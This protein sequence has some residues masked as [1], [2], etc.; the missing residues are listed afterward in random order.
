MS[1]GFD[2]KTIRPPAPKPV[3]V[4]DIGTTSIRMAVAEI[5]DGGNVRPLE[6]LSLAVSLGK[7]TF[8]KGRITK[9][10]IEECVNVLKSYRQVLTEYQINSPDQIR[11][12]ATSA[13]REAS[14]RLAFLDRI[15][16][17]TGFRV[18]PIEEAEENRVT[19]LGILPFLQSEPALS[20]SKAMVVPSAVN[21]SEGTRASRARWS[22]ACPVRPR[23]R[24]DKGS[25]RRSRY[26]GHR[27][28]G[29]HR[30]C[31][32]VPSRW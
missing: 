4:I 26:S 14:N 17:A 9:S 18:E 27:R 8:T 6:S 32:W 21:R 22:K 1:Q 3:A 28:S 25:R 19:Y 30:I 7:D 10:T 5:S 24:R 31:S 15:Y 20:V 16:I 2:E 29:C 11:V 23:V 12:V 13:V